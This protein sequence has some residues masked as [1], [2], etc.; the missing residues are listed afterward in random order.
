MM[1]DANK[2]AELVEQGKIHEAF[3]EAKGDAGALMVLTE[4]VL[5]WGTIKGKPGRDDVP[6]PLWPEHGGPAGELERNDDAWETEDLDME[7]VEGLLALQSPWR[8]ITDPD[9]RYGSMETSFVKEMKSHLETLRSELGE[10][11]STATQSFGQR[12]RGTMRRHHYEAYR[13]GRNKSGH[14][15]LREN[16]LAAAKKILAGEY[17]YLRGFAA[18]LRAK[19][20]KDGNID[21]TDYRASMYG[22]SLRRAFNAGITS[23]LADDDVIVISEGAVETEHCAEC[24][25]RWGSYTPAEFADIGGNPVDWC[26]GFTRCKCIVSVEKAERK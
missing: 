16:D 24:P 6:I 12:A 13:T 4:Y 23:E 1:A 19:W 9:K 17:S 2:I 20:D 22:T 10:G 26:E 7:T 21:G 14:A 25:P 3:E 8:G 18:D 11:K 5:M 15:G